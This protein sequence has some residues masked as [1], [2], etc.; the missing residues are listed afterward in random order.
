MNIV[1]LSAL[2]VGS[3]TF[4]GAVAGFLFRGVSKSFCDMIMS[5]AA[6]VMLIAAILGLVVPALELG[7]AVS[8]ILCV[9]GIFL[10]AVCLYLA[11]RAVP[12]LEKLLIGT[13][14][15]SLHIHSVLVFVLAIAI[16][17]LPEG[18]A[19]GVSFGSGDTAKALS[20]VLGI[21][22]QNVPEGMVIIAPML[23]IGFSEKKTFL[24]ASFT[25]IVE[26]FGT[27][28]GYF[29][30]KISSLLLPFSLGFAAGTMLY[31]IC[32]E[33]IPSSHT[34]RDE[35]KN[36]FGFVFGVCAMLIFDAL[37]A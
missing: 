26:V 6:G 13:N 1:L 35:K 18:L 25:G 30:A 21:A 3:A 19:A 29:T 15:G 4:F 12:H 32:D 20:V 28:I 22:L 2:G 23:S 24:L 33:M 34:A 27:M 16:H 7:G 8:L 5:F 36:S 17:N 11:D 37:I 10:G 9:A 31:V 14:T